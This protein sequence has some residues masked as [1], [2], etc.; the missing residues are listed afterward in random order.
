MCVKL[1]HLFTYT[2]RRMGNDPKPNRLIF[3]CYETG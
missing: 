1:I 3:D 2:V